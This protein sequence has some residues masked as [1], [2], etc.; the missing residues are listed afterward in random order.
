MRGCGMEQETEVERGKGW[1]GGEGGSGKREAS[2]D[3]WSGQWCRAELGVLTGETEAAAARG[4]TAW[5]ATWASD[6]PANPTDRSRAAASSL[7]VSSS[8]PCRCPPSRPSESPASHRGELRLAD[9]NRYHPPWPARPTRS[10]PRPT[11]P[12]Q[13]QLHETPF[14]THPVGPP[15]VEARG[16]GPVERRVLPGAYS[17]V[18]ESRG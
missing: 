16:G 5:E 3:V 10:R 1:V 4:P 6:S 7:Q 17:Q 14:S 9:P 12:L 11:A 18:C 8:Y 15:S 2:A 13:P